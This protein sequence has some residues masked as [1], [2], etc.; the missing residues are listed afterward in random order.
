[1]TRGG[2]LVQ[3]FLTR[4]TA[5]FLLC[6]HKGNREW[7]L[8]SA[9]GG[10]VSSRT[11]FPSSTQL[12]NNSDHE[13]P[14]SINHF[15]PGGYPWLVIYLFCQILF[16]TTIINTGQI[17]SLGWKVKMKLAR[18]VQRHIAVTRTRSFCLLIQAWEGLILALM[19]DQVYYT[20]HATDWK[21]K[22]CL[23]NCLLPHH[24]FKFRPYGVLPSA[25]IDC[26]RQGWAQIQHVQYLE[27]TPSHLIL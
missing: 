13:G 1:M 6:S 7:F 26:R 23:G 17:A 10:Y 20:C 21:R 19:R 25:C 18:Q 22:G 9:L 3:V 4:M 15:H 14:E 8:S 2:V 11:L 24:C 12:L 27:H 16:F 5:N